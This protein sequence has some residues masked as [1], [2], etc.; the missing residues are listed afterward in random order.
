VS[1]IH[2]KKGYQWACNFFIAAGADVPLTDFVLLQ[3]TGHQFSLRNYI[4]A[5]KPCTLRARLP[6]QKKLRSN[7]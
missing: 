5:T 2:L 4:H 6:Y 1:Q 3:E 7:Y